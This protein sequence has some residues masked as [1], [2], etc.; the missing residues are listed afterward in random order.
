M[1]II[2]K[3]EAHS[4]NWQHVCKRLFMLMHD[5]AVFKF[6]IVIVM[7]IFK[8]VILKNGWISYSLVQ[9]VQ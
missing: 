1:S 8:L 4:S 5:C 3:T 7:V 6:I 2:R 9:N